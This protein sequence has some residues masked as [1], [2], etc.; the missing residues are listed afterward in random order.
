MSFSILPSIAYSKEYKE[1]NNTSCNFKS[2]LP[3]IQS[4]DKIK[5]CYLLSPALSKGMKVSCI[6]NNK[7]IEII[8]GDRISDAYFYTLNGLVKE[9]NFEN[10]Q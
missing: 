5:S 4:V 3:S 8:S 2:F 10:T 9:L 7:M 1:K 6:R